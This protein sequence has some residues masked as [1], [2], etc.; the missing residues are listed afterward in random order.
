MKTEIVDWRGKPRFP[1]RKLIPIEVAYPEE[2]TAAHATLSRYAALRKA[3]ATDRTETFATEFVL[4][5]LKK[6]LFS[7]PEAFRLTLEKHRKSV[8]AGASVGMAQLRRQI[9]DIDEEFADDDA[10]DR[11]ESDALEAA[12][13]TTRALSRDELAALDQLQRFADRASAQ[14]DEKAK[15]L[16]AWLET[17][18][19]PERQLDRPARHHLHRVPRNPEVAVRA[20]RRARLRSRRSTAPSVRRHAEG[21]A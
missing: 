20:A 8:G 17:N 14:A 16:I 9:E 4:K 7:S 15:K 5:L 21:Q 11:A 1:C 6:R 13:S 19:R 3:T 10:Y 18:I 12:S 2:E